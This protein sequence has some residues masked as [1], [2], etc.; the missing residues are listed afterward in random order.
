MSGQSL[1]SFQSQRRSAHPNMCR[2]SVSQ[3]ITTISLTVSQ[4]TATK[5]RPIE[6]SC[7]SIHL[8]SGSLDVS[9]HLTLASTSV[10]YKRGL[11]PYP[12]IGFR[13]D[14]QRQHL[15]W[16]LPTG[17]SEQNGNMRHISHTHDQILENQTGTQLLSKIFKSFNSKV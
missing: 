14:Y 3:W 8:S 17:T 2:E 4:G 10:V 11:V 12:L 15:P 6:E 7:D 5:R 16:E 9:A 1:N 13:Y